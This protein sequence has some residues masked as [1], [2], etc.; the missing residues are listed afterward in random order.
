MRIEPLDLTAEKTVRA[1]YDVLRA[2]Q[3]MDDPVE[4]P[5]SLPMFGVFLRSG[6]EATPA[7]VWVA[8]DDS[9]LDDRDQGAGGTVLGYY[10]M[11]LP[12][13]ENLDR[14]SGGP[15]VAPA[16]RRRGIGR[17]LL[18]HL[19]GR[20]A[21]NGRT[22]LDAIV[23]SGSAGEAFALAAGARPDLEEIR[24]VQ[25]LRKIEP[26]TVAALRATAERAAAGYS[27]VSW[28][29]PVPE[30]YLGPLAEVINAFA[31]AP[32][33]ESV[34]AEVWDADR[35][36]ERTSVLLRAGVARGHA[37]A[38]VHAA[39]GEMAAFTGVLID[40]ETPRCGYQQLTAVIRTHRGHR[41]GLLVKTAML[42]LLATAEPQLEEIQTGNA[43]ENAYMI[44]VNETL[45]YAVVPPG[46]RTY[47]IPVGDV[48]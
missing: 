4:P 7:E 31:D 10:R 29:G 26:G 41:L 19:A 18:R 44:A 36:R 16:L 32:R 13:L 38:A 1:C 25:Y 46:W 20:A 11:E 48:R 40:P 42:E 22:V 23:T 28:D 2:A 21:A 3:A 14:A 39:T 37:V 45:G 12:D 24:R 15:V 17:E 9:G 6:W 47:E 43:A 27:L 33:G 34:E 35:V 30:Q 8:L 5:P